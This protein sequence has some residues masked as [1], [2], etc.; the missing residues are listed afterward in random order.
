M[1]EADIFFFNYLANLKQGR[2][3]E[4]TDEDDQ[5]NEASRDSLSSRY[6]S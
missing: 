5:L 2:T 6:P 4:A 3:K 1:S